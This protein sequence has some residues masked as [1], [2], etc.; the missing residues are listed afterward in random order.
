MLRDPVRASCRLPE[1]SLEF[2]NKTVGTDC[3]KQSSDVENSEFRKGCDRHEG[4]SPQIGKAFPFARSCGEYK[5][6]AIRFGSPI[7]ITPDARRSLLPFHRF[8]DGS[9]RRRTVR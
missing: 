5:P 6:L 7:D 1:C 3:M 4:K 2:A 9:R 8:V